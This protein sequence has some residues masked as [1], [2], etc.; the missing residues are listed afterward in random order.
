MS[1]ERHVSLIR[2]GIEILSIFID[3]NDSHDMAIHVNWL[4]EKDFIASQVVVTN[5]G[6]PR[7]LHFGCLWKLSST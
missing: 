7:L 1:S 2:A 3:S 5:K 6:L 4:L